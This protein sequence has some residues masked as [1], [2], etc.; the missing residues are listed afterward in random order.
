MKQTTLEVDNIHF[1]YDQRLNTE[2]LSD[3]SFTASQG[4]W[5]AIIGGNGSGKSTLAKLLVGLYP[6]KSG[7]IKVDQLTVKEDTLSQVRQKIGIVFQNPDNQWIGTTV[8]DDIAFALENSNIPYEEMCSR[9]DEAVAMMELTDLRYCDPSRLSGGQKQ[10]VAV[11]GVLA[12]RPSIIVLDEALV[13]L[14]PKSRMELLATLHRLRKKE[15]ITI[16]SIT[17]DMNEAA[18]SDYILVMNRGRIVKSGRPVDIFTSMEQEA[19]LPFSERLRRTLR[20]RDISVP[21]HYVNESDLIKF[22][23]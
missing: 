11:A 3:I 6:V 8:E 7:E 19:E 18:S 1:Q 4:D 13:M 23:K 10:R 16:I 20:E 17:H 15:K 9:V 21:S 5:L 22:L 14:D 12:L 2:T